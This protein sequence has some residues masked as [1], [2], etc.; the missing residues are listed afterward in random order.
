MI[1]EEASFRRPVTAAI[2]VITVP[3][4]GDLKSMARVNAMLGEDEQAFKFA[5]L[6]NVGE[7]IPLV[8]VIERIRENSS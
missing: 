3:S 6:S 8:L 7:N 4:Y 2:D 1:G 5:T